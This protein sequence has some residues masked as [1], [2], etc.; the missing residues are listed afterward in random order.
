MGKIYICKSPSKCC[1]RRELP[2]NRA[3]AY[4]KLKRIREF[5]SVPTT[6]QPSINTLHHYDRSHE[7]PSIFM[8]IYLGSVSS[9]QR[10]FRANTDDANPSHTAIKL[11]SCYSSQ[12][13]H[14]STIRPLESFDRVSANSWTSPE[15]S[16]ISHPLRLSVLLVLVRLNLRTFGEDLTL[17]PC[18]AKLR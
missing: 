11:A 6:H 17:L 7:H 8:S 16:C 10:S 5:S 4:L 2:E 18:R 9:S 14:G 13:Q 15:H 12:I 3:M 1:Q